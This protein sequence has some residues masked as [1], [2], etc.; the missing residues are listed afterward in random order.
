MSVRRL[1]LHSQ[2]EAHVKAQLP[3]FLRD[4]CGGIGCGFKGWTQEEGRWRTRRPPKLFDPVPVPK[5]RTFGLNPCHAGY[6]RPS[7]D[8][9]ADGGEAEELEWLRKQFDP[10]QHVPKG[11]AIKIQVRGPVRAAHASRSPVLSSAR[12]VRVA[13]CQGEPGEGR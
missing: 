9:A 8:A 10:T 6:C 5:K 3:T 12:P 1:I 13:E 4:R 7:M 2:T 11:T